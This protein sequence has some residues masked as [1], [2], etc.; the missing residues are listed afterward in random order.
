MTHSPGRKDAN[1]FVNTTLT[2][3]YGAKHVSKR[4]SPG[5]KGAITLVTG[6]FLFILVSVED[7]A[8][9]VATTLEA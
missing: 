8:V 3:S 7:M 4:H 6:V 5:L 1:T 9:Q 2:W